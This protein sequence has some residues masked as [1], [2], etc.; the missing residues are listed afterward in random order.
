M[1]AM[2]LTRH[3][4]AAALFGATALASGTTTYSLGES[5]GYIVGCQ[6]P[7][8]CPLIFAESLT[9]TFEL[10]YSNS[11]ADNYDHYAVSNVNWTLVF[12]GNTFQVTGSGQ[13]EIGGPVATQHRLRLD[14]S[15]D[16]G[17]VQL[18]DSGLKIASSPI[19]DLDLSIALNGFYCYDEVFRVDAS[20][21]TL[22]VKTCDSL[23]NSSG[24]AA[25]VAA[26][27]SASVATN[28]FTLMAEGLPAGQLGIFFFGQGAQQM[29]F[30][31]GYLCLSSSITRL[32][33]AIPV[34]ASGSVQRDVDLTQGPAAGQLVPGSTWGF[35]FWFRDPLGGPSGFN[36]SDAVMVDFR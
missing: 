11:T 2:K 8:K 34:G 22:G 15:F 30:G 29:P 23:A 19:P 36:L 6:P 5:A 9:G 12:S 31:E 27:G 3:V 21:T 16:G 7:C 17:P 13:Y 32:V 10:A 28:D 33:P 26:A 35:Q 25:T 14:L 24:Q 1:L 20:P 4:L 18:F